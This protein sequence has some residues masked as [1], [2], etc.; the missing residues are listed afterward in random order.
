MRIGFAVTLPEQIDRFVPVAA[1]IPGVR[2]IVPPGRWPSAWLDSHQWTRKILLGRERVQ[3]AEAQAC[4]DLIVTGGGVR[5]ESLRPWQHPAGELVRFVDE[6]AA[7]PA[8]DAELLAPDS[9]GG[10]PRIE[11]ALEPATRARARANLGLSSST[12]RP[13]VVIRAE[14]SGGVSSHFAP[15][16]SRLRFEF[17]LIVAPANATWLHGRTPVPRALHGPGIAI[18]RD[19]L[20]WA[21]LLA[22]ADVVI[23][24]PGA[25]AA[26]AQ[27]LGKPLVLLGVERARR[28]GQRSWTGDFERAVAVRDPGQLEA[29]LWLAIDERT[30]IQ[31]TLTAELER[32]GASARCARW[33]TDRASTRAVDRV[34]SD[35]A[36]NAPSP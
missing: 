13:C 20:S 22:V 28:L 12:S 11:V 29:A 7:P 3:I 27:R 35:A 36:T 21:E 1:R 4:L 32:A 18:V 24:E 23:A 2:W 30:A 31:S 8:W 5:A 17:D 10:D 26:D 6:W 34:L 14:E 16:L 19:R 33:L 15:E 9:F 25:F